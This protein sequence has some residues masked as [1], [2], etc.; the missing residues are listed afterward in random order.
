MRL[1]MHMHKIYT[2]LVGSIRQVLKCVWGVPRE[3]HLRVT[4]E[5]GEGVLLRDIWQAVLTTK[6]GNMHILS[7][8]EVDKSDSD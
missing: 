4:A 3:G 6:E 8:I 1:R 2:L 7:V 5:E